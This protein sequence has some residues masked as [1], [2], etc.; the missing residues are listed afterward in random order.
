MREMRR[1]PTIGLVRDLVRAAITVADWT[2]EADEEQYEDAVDFIWDQYVPKRH[3]F[4][5]QVVNSLVDWGWVVFELVYE[6]NESTK[7]VELTKVKQLLQ[8]ITDMLVDLNGRFVGVKNMAQSMEQVVL[9]AD[10]CLMIDREVEGTN[11]YGE[12]IM[13]RAEDAYLDSTAVRES[14]KRYDKKVAGAHWVVWYPPGYTE[15][16][17]SSI[18]NLEVANRILNAME[19]NGK[20]AIPNSVARHVDDL[21]DLGDDKKAWKI[22]LLTAQSQQADFVAREEH[23]NKLKVRA[24]GVPER[25]VLEGQ[26]GTK[27]EAEAHADFAID[28]IEMMGRDIINAINEQS[29]RYLL[30]QNYGEEYDGHVKIRQSP[31]SDAKRAFLRSLFQSFLTTE[32]G[33]A[34]FNDSVDWEGIAEEL[35]VPL[36]GTDVQEGDSTDGTPGTDGQDGLGES[37]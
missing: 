20:F 18:S 15:I 14:A 23:L 22:E 31:L 21:N 37:P 3:T 17:G 33:I 27:A 13:R 12:P 9:P 29:V 30:V 26:F 2:V 4:L 34:L 10:K 19:S 36:T 7:Q 32:Q 6:L 5:P 8:D 25:S 35:G 1:D 11:W 16:G 24:F 28:N